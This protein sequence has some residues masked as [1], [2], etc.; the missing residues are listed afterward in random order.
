MDKRK[1]Q[2]GLAFPRWTDAFHRVARAVGNDPDCHWQVDVRDLGFMDLR[3]LSHQIQAVELDGLLVCA[4][5]DT[6]RAIHHES[7]G[8]PVPCVGLVFDLTVLGRPAAVADTRHI[9]RLLVDHLKTLEVGQWAFVGPEDVHN[10]VQLYDHVRDHLA[11][12]GCD[13]AYYHEPLAGMFRDD[14][15]E[16]QAQ[17]LRWLESLAKPAVI[18]CF[19]PYQ[20]TMFKRLALQNGY[21]VP[22]D[23]FIAVSMDEPICLMS[24]PAITAVS[25]PFERMGQ[26]AMRLMVDWLNSGNPPAEPLARVVDGAELIVRQST[27]SVDPDRLAIERAVQYIREHG[28]T[29]DCVDEVIEQTQY[30]SRSKFFNLFGQ[31][32]GT[33]PYAMLREARMARAR[34]LLTETNLSVGRVAHQCGYEEPRHFSTAFRAEVGLPPNAYRKSHRPSP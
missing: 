34:Q 6:L 9:A 28:C 16:P 4:P 3:E 10:S 25:C 1:W 27:G 14:W 8:P 33:T 20:A 7:N 21:R 2:V 29:I 26:T 5:L 17:V 30:M 18:I 19:S 22:G 13:L 32:T 31:H 11:D 24:E 15:P 12:S 23:L